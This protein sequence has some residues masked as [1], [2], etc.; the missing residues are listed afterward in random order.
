MGISSGLP[1]KGREVC[2]DAGNRL[3]ALFGRARIASVKERLSKKVGIEGYM[4]VRA[5]SSI[6]ENKTTR[7]SSVETKAVFECCLVCEG[8]VRR[9]KARS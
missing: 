6:S 2:A 1:K 8:G 5:L 9:R 3:V 4:V 7:V